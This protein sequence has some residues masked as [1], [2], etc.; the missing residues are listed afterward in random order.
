M[1]KCMCVIC[2]VCSHNLYIASCL[3]VCAYMLSFVLCVRA[4]VRVCMRECVHVCVCVYVLALDHV[5]DPRWAVGVEQQ[6]NNKKRCSTRKEKKVDTLSFISL[7]SHLFKE[8]KES[9]FHCSLTLSPPLSC[10]QMPFDAFQVNQMCFP[11]AM[12]SNRKVC[13]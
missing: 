1:Y 2:L 13:V 3:V 11:A 6:S 4:C 8:R 12:H 5:C 9:L 10:S 7:S